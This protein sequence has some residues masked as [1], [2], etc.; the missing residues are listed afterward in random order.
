VSSFSLLGFVD[1]HGGGNML[2]FA[3]TNSLMT[4]TSNFD[5]VKYF[6]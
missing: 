1:L 5:F 6:L 4:K 3:I 2:N